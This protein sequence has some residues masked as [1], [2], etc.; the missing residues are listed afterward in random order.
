M[1]IRIEP[2]GDARLRLSGDV[3]TVLHL[4]PKAVQDGFAIAVSDGTLLRGSYDSERDECSFSVDVE[5]AGLIAIARETRGDVVD[6]GWR[7]DWISVAAGADALC[8]AG[9]SDDDLQQEFRFADKERR[10]A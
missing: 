1:S 10:A 2:C 4:S 3:E 8:P 6:L 9:A 5:G 7:I